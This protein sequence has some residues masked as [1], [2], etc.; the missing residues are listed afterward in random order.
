MSD[1][2]NVRWANARQIAELIDP[3]AARTIG[4]DITPQDHFDALRAAGALE[5][6]AMF[7]AL[8]LARFDAV[9]W[10]ARAVAAAA[11]GPDADDATRS[12]VAAWINEATD[13]RRR[14]C[15]TA[16]QAAPEDSTGRLLGYAVF[17][18]GGSI[19]ERDMP[20]VNPALDLAGRLAAAA[21]IEAAHRGG[22]PHAVLDAALATG[23]RLARGRAA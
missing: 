12:A 6:A 20:M 4:E 16:A 13:E 21:L 22:A 9:A 1:W 3:V 11:A 18:S 5:D 8:A 10:A 7:L 14:A 17:L 2:T 15:W 19:S 23:D